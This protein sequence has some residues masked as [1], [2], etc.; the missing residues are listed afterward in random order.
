[1]QPSNGLNQLL[2]QV[3]ITVGFVTLNRLIVSILVFV[4]GLKLKTSLL[5]NSSTF[6]VGCV[7]VHLG[8]RLLI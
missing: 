3:T 7:T 8:T 1:M 4:Q 5:A 6:M 2:N